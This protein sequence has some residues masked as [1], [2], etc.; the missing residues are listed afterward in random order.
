MEQIRERLYQ[1]KNGH[2]AS[3]WQIILTVCS[4][5]GRATK[6]Y[7]AYLGISDTKFYRIVSLYNQQ[8]ASFCATLKWGGRREACCLISPEQEEE[9]L[10]NWTATAL[11]GGV[12]VAKQ[13]RQAVEQ[14]AGH[15][16]S[17]DYLWDLLH[18]H[19]WTKKTPRPEH[20]RAAEVK[21]KREA[22]KKKHP[23]SSAPKTKMQSP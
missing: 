20:C 8:G 21:E 15:R 5:P 18:R 11:E 13:L 7:C 10:Q 22:F 3:Y 2:H 23:N 16:V 12:L 4:N 17:D 14:K 9:L 6:E 1:S 19:G